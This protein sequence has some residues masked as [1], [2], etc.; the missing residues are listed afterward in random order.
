MRLS[1]KCFYPKKC[2][3]QL[4][5][6]LTAGKSSCFGPGV[7]SV[8]AWAAQQLRR[9]LVTS[10]LQH[11]RTSSFRS[12][13]SPNNRTVKS[14][15]VAAPWLWC[16]DA[17]SG[18]DTAIVSYTPTDTKDGLDLRRNWMQ[19]M[20]LG[21]SVWTKPWLC[22]FQ[23]GV[24]LHEKTEYDEEGDIEI[25][26]QSQQIISLA[27]R[28]LKT[29]SLALSAGKQVCIQLIISH[30]LICSQTKIQRCETPVV[31]L[32]GRKRL[33]FCFFLFNQPGQSQFV[34]FLLRPVFMLNYPPPG[35]ESVSI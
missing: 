12:T 22:A 10:A 7:T 21:L 2:G 26:S 32:V 34:C 33:L 17:L 31:C 24:S 5:D 13:R 11:G 1:V 4:G 3:S 15:Q 14:C 35:S 19:R 16:P 27:W 30:C 23:P 25:V 20:N 8:S 28:L 6:V 18:F 29:A 9:L